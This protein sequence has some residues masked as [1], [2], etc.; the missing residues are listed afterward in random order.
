VNIKLGKFEL[1]NL[2]SEKRTL[3]LTA[4]GGAYQIYHFIPPG[5]GPSG[6][7][8]NDGNIFGQLGDNQL[9]VEWLGHS[10][11]DRTRVSAALLS[12]TDGNVDVPYGQNSYSG[13]F[14]ASHAFDVGKLGTDRVGFYAMVGAAPTS[15][16]TSGGAPILSSGT[17]NKTFSRE[18]F[19][20]LF[21]FGKLDF[22]VV[23][24]HG[25]KKKEGV[26]RKKGMVQ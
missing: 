9:G 23:S 2:V 12:T 10:L 18:G 24:Q 7:T 8:I 22:Q 20:G 25:S 4:S 26:Q 11:N 6:I 17:G 15:F 19:V 21:Y 14:A 3:T 1:D 13:F 5:L 16:L